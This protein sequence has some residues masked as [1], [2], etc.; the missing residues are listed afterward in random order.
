MTRAAGVSDDRLR[1][2][3]RNRAVRSWRS[4]RVWSQCPALVFP[5]LL[6]LAGLAGGFRQP[7]LFLFRASL[8]HLPM[9]LFRPILISLSALSVLLL[10]SHRSVAADSLHTDRCQRRREFWSSRRSTPSIVRARPTSKL[11]DKNV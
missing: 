3:R 8:G 6:L 10:V 5:L 11:A 7:F 1:Q 9:G 4:L 2:G